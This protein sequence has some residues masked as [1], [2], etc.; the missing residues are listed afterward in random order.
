MQGV[1][2]YS[3]SANSSVPAM[4]GSMVSRGGLP[5]GARPAFGAQRRNMSTVPS[6]MRVRTC[7]YMH[8]FFLAG[9]WT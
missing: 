9:L 8:H 7:T 5:W 2:F 3:T 6:T 1:K 4:G